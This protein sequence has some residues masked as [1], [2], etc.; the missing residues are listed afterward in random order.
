MLPTLFLTL[1]SLSIQAPAAP[2]ASGSSAAEASLSD[3]SEAKTATAEELR[4]RI[5]AMRM[6]L[7]MGGDRV[8]AAEA[9]AVDFYAQKR[10]L[11]EQR[12]DSIDA[13]LSEKRATYDVVTQRALNERTADQRRKALGEAADLRAQLSSLEGESTRLI[14]RRDRLREMV[15]AVEARDRDRQKLAA[16][17]ET[18]TLR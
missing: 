9:E 4:S 5:H 12:L 15:G 3:E 6:D 2:A 18:S 11:V 10:E 13:E 7:L 14:E 17:L 16:E 1:A 8:R